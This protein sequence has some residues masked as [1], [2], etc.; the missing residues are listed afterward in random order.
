[1]ENLIL[2]PIASSNPTIAVLWACRGCSRFDSRHYS[3]G[4]MAD[5]GCIGDCA[6]KKVFTEQRRQL[7]SSRLSLSLFWMF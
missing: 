7:F 3:I 4:F 6:H 2:I 1:M 5:V